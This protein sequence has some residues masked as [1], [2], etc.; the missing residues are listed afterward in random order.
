MPFESI[1][2]LVEQL[3]GSFVEKKT[4]GKEASF[5]KAQSAI[6]RRLFEQKTAELY[7]TWI[8]QVKDRAYIEKK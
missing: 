2:L 4:G 7:Q 5:E 6:R 8:E 1:Y 3:L